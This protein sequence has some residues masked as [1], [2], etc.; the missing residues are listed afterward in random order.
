MARRAGLGQE[1]V[2]RAN[3][4]ALLTQVHLQGPTTRAALTTTLGLNRS[5]IGD[6]TRQLEEIGLLVEVPP[7]EEPVVP[8]RRSGRPSL[9]VAPRE[10]VTVLA[11]ALDVDRITVAIVGLGGVVLDRRTRL[12]QRGEHDGERVAETVAQMCGELIALG[13]GSRLVGV[14]VSVP[15]AVRESDGMVRFAPNLGW[16]DVPFADLL[17]TELSLPVLTANDADLGVLAEHMRGAAVGADD[18]AY[19]SGSVGI[20]GGFF[21]RGLPLRGASGFAGEVGHV[22]VDS[23]GD[24]CRCGAVG[25]LETKVGENQ[26][27]AAAGRLLGGGPPAV[28][29]LIKAA[30]AGDARAGRAVDGVAHWLG[31]GLRPVFALFNPEVVVLGGLL[32]QVFT[33]RRTIVLEGLAPQSLISARDVLNIRPS[34]LGDDASLIGAAELA[35]APLLAEPRLAQEALPATADA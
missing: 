15:G 31:V 25:C 8:G 6:L 1:A 28:A 32:S 2:R 4:S 19:L 3:M 22:M 33:A 34:A 18:V 5:T 20:G 26:L 10:D 30:D 21:V 12:H 27:L 11:I 9:V 29:E 13:L 24:Q 14:G 7:G 17:A 35:F 23:N 16:T